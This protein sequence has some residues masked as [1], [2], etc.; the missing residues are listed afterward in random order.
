M[1]EI[2]VMVVVGLLFAGM[3]QWSVEVGRKYEEGRWEGT[4]LTA[5][6]DEMW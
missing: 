3:R 5:A 6:V 1:M 2:C 4:G